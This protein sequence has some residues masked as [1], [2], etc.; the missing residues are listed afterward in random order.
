MRGIQ[1]CSAA[2]IARELDIH[3]VHSQ[4]YLGPTG[5]QSS[6]C[7]LGA[8]E[9]HR[10]L[11]SSL[12]GTVWAFLV[13]IGHI[14]LIT[15]RS[16]GAETWLITQNLKPEKGCVVEKLSSSSSKENQSIV[17]SKD[18]HG[19]TAECYCSTFSLWQP[20]FAKGLGFF[21]IIL[22][23]CMQMPGIIQPTGLQL[24]MAVH[25]IGHGSVPNLRSV[26]CLSLNL[27]KHLAG[28]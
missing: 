6:V 19:N 5:L 21:V 9:F 18:D 14:T 22:S 12:Y 1:T 10:W 28:K 7:T 27:E 13:S 24:F 20:F 26:F 3:W 2:E 25:L 4:N 8:K 15:E 11:Q 17:I 23:F 16:F